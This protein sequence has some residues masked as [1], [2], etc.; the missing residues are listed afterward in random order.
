MN[1]K[2]HSLT[3]DGESYEFVGKWQLI[4]SSAGCLPDSEPDVY[5]TEAEA[6]EA[7]KDEYVYEALEA[8]K[9]EYVYE[10]LEALK[11][12]Y[13]YGAEVAETLANASIEDIKL[14]TWDSDK[15]GFSHP[16]NSLYRTYIEQIEA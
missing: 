9:D 13:V 16:G 3:E 2:P 5:D 10:A 14:P 12:E 4:T 6:L 1:T 8:L 11:D 7:L 15:H